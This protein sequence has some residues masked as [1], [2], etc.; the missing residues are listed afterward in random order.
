[1][2]TLTKE[3]LN[4]V[5]GGGLYED[6]PVEVIREKARES[7]IFMKSKGDPFDYAA[8]MISR[9]YGVSGKIEWD[10]ITLIVREVYFG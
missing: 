5:T 10:E 6:A 4:E 2:T 3:M 1:M 9:Y 8:D 7:A